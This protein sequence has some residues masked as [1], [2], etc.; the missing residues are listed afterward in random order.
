MRGNGGN[1]EVLLVSGKAPFTSEGLELVVRVGAN[2]AQRL[3]V[4]SAQ[5]EDVYER[6]L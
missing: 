5:V 6:F 4:F 3:Y 1:P 2:E